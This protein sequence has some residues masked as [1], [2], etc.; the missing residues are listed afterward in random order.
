MPRPSAF[1]WLSL[2][3]SIASIGFAA[4]AL[5]LAKIGLDGQA[6]LSESNVQLS[7]ELAAVPE[8]VTRSVADALPPPPPPTDASLNTA[9][10][11]T[12]SSTATPKAPTIRWT[13]SP[14]EI[15]PE[16][17]EE[18]MQQLVDVLK[19]Q[20]SSN[21]EALHVAALMKAQTRQ[22]AEAQALWSECLR[23]APDKELFYINVASIGM[24]QGNND[25]AL[26]ILNQGV[27]R[28]FGSLDLIQHLGIVLSKLGKHEESLQRVEA[29]L[30]KF[31][32]AVP[33]LLLSGQA[34][35]ELGQYPQSESQFRKA[36]ELGADTS[37]LYVGL[38]NACVRQGKREEGSRYLK[39]YADRVAQDKLSGQDRYDKLS[40]QEIKQTAIAVF[41]EAA[42]F[43]FRQK[44]K[45]QA[46]RLLMRCVAI[47]PEDLSGLRALADLY[48]KNKMLAE[49]RFVRERILELGTSRFSD[50]LDLAKVCA[51]LN[52]NESAEA[53]L[54][55]AMTSNP[56]SIEPLATLAQ[57][58]LQSNRLDH[59]KWYAQQSI[60]RQPSAEGFRFLASI[61]HLQKD[62]IGEVEAIRL[63]K[64]LEAKP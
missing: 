21:S 20:Y 17:L 25:L 35:L 59:A 47:A 55:S 30:Q 31:P 18:E 53:V 4:T 36:M 58:Y 49:E 5:L 19:G 14:T 50:Y 8:I 24:E 26:S 15:Q 37:S 23:L 10:P 11:K 48:F 43:Y 13:R 16:L 22:F 52:D 39:I 57:F 2:F 42:A 6:R 9:N 54:K 60:E 61:C 33:L 38:G 64:Q 44:D 3:L 27:H 40:N 32:N 12:T 1:G 63:A 7:K 41:T 46:E 34:Y 28:G 45:L 56:L 29:G 51:Q 62:A